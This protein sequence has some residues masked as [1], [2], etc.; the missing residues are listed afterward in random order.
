MKLVVAQVYHPELV[1]YFVTMRISYCIPN[2]SAKTYL[3]CFQPTCRNFRAGPTRV[4]SLNWR[5]KRA[6]GSDPTEGVE[7][8]AIYFCTKRNAMEINLRFFTGL[9]NVYNRCGL[10]KGRSFHDSQPWFFHHGKK[11]NYEIGKQGMYL[12]KSAKTWSGFVYQRK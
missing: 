2:D 12:W 3:T 4:W 1:W 7:K 5:V 10:W 6:N 11:K 8:Y 9:R